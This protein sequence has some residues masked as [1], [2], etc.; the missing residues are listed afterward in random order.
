MRK[1]AGIV[2][3]ATCLLAVCLPA[4]ASA[5]VYFGFGFGNGYWDG[6]HGSYPYYRPWRSYRYYHRPWHPYYRPFIR[7]RFDYHDYYDDEEYGYGDDDHVARCEAHYRS[8]NPETDM[9]LGYDGEYHY[10]RL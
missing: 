3:A 1:L 5:Q 2:A 9:F 8:Y 6:Y 7:P 10:C 4:P